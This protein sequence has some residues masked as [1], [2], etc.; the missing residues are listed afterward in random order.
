M[1]KLRPDLQLD[2]F[3]ARLAGRRQGILMLDYDG[4][5][6]PLAADPEGVR[7][8]PGVSEVLDA[9]M[10]AGH[11][12]L[13]VVTG[14]SLHGSPPRLGM[15]RMPE[16]WGSHGRE[17][18][19]EDGSYTVMGIEEPVARALVMADEWGPEVEA[20]GGRCETKPGCVAFHWRGLEV[21]RA[22][23]LRQLLARRYRMQLPPGVIEWHDFDGGAEMRAP[24][25]TKAAAVAGIL[26]D[27]PAALPVAYLGD[28]ITDEDAFGALP[29]DGL[30]V[31]VRPRFR[32]TAADVWLRPPEELL[33]FLKI[34]H[35]T[36]S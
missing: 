27:A 10:D 32:P 31:L 13:V 9:L 2:A 29:A 19:L 23:R 24:G 25:T 36:N 12:R 6:A 14:R 17:R 4:T 34:W 33:A 3:M 28:D 26:A 20:A 21:W 5:L 15:R 7:P 11:T 1:E 35:R 30:R 16:L 22:R 8:Y 18:L